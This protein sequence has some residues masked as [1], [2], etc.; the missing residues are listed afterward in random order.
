MLILIESQQLHHQIHVIENYRINHKTELKKGRERERRERK[1][2]KREK[3]RE[4]ERKREKEREREK[5]K[6]RRVNKKVR[7]KSIKRRNISPFLPQLI[8]P[9]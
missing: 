6:E 2:E 9:M 4:R 1:R 8:V 5:E 3:E 7:E